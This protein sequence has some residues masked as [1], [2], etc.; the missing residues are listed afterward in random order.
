MKKSLLLTVIASSFVLAIMI[1][2]CQSKRSTPSTP[3]SPATAT[4]TSTPSSPPTATATATADTGVGYIT[5]TVTLPGSKSGE[6]LKVFI[7]NN[8]IDVVNN[9]INSMKV[10]LDTQTSVAF[11]L[12]ATAGTY[13]VIAAVMPSVGPP[14]LGDYVGIYGATYPAFPAARNVTVHGGLTTTADVAAQTVVNSI[15]GTITFPAAVSATPHYYFVIM[16]QTAAS[17]VTGQNIFGDEN[18]IIGMVPLGSTTSPSATSITYSIPIL[19]PGSYVISVLV[20]STNNGEIIS[21]G[22]FVGTFTTGV[23]DP[24]DNYTNQNFTLT[25]QP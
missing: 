20:D 12:T 11:S 13:Y 23:L 3:S 9:Q 22:D 16:K 8:L 10:A 21:T 5:G 14:A 17:F 24:A 15:S 1:S 6:E 4:A 18:G 25:T 7:V 19:I 2:G